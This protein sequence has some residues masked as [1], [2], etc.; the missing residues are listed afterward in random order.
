MNRLFGSPLKHATGKPLE[1]WLM[2]IDLPRRKLA[3]ANDPAVVEKVMLS[4]DGFPK[5]TVIE[6]LLQ[7]LIGSGVF[8]QPGGDAVKE[9][10]RLFARSLA[11]IPDDHIRRA[12]EELTAE[13]LE[14]WL[15]AGRIGVSEEF[16]RLT[17]DVASVCTLGDRFDAAESKRF[18]ELFLNYHLDASPFAVLLAR[19]DQATRERIVRELGLPETGEKMREM[20]RQRFVR[21]VLDIDDPALMAPFPRA[22]A[23]AGKVSRDQQE[24]VVDEIAVMLLAGH[25]TTASTLSW[26]ALELAER[27]ELQERAAGLIAG[28]GDGDDSWAALDPDRVVNALADETLRLYPPIGFFLRENTADVT[29]RGKSLP[30]GSFMVVAPWTLHRHRELWRDADAF[31]PDRWLDGSPAPARTAFMPF[32]LGGRIC[33]GARFAGVEMNAIIRGLLSKAR[34]SLA[35]GG[36]P[37]PLG[38]LTLRPAREIYLTVTPRQA[39]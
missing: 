9:T 30:A 3:L 26:L 29:F 13:Y 21:P 6:A 39:P 24:R 14:R 12:T 16:S 18:T 17:V 15:S 4:R 37:E 23:E 31:D 5:S 7:P 2:V 33:P 35:D 20:V 38:T 28:A 27:P 1:R 11:A 36:R 25:E 19:G 34:L 8:G 22:L 10:R 32:G